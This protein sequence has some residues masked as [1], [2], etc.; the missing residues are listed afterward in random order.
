MQSAIA[1]REGIRRVNGAPVI[2]VCVFLATLAAALPFSIVMRESLRGSF[3]HS[4]AANEAARGV[5]HE[6]WT[7]YSS[8]ASGLETTFTTSVIGFAAVL[9]NLSTLLDRDRRP[10]AILWMGAGYLLLWL[11]LS[12]GLLDRLA[13]NRPIRSHGFFA[14]CGV[15]FGRLLRLAPRIALAYYALFRYVHAWLFDDLYP[16]VTRELSVERTAFL[17]RLALYAVFGLLLVAVNMLFDYA[18]VRA[19]VEDRRS[20]IGAV[21]AAARF[22]K[23]NAAAAVTLYFLN[24]LLFVAVLAPYAL[25]APGAGPAGPMMWAGVAVSQL[26]LAARVWV[27]LV[28]LASEVSLFQSRLA[29]AGYIA[30]PLAPRAEPPIVEQLVSEIRQ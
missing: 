23:R 10:G 1:L 15:Y 18:K 5:N 25:A 24:G 26:Y 28:F 29:A 9:D 2:V 20:M 16:G 3:D 6:W 11:F 4:L 12:G 19:V 17:W 21:A 8:H 7:E 14:A 27:R 22:L 30:A 13:R